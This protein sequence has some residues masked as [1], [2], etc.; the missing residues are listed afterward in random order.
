MFGCNF[1]LCISVMTEI[2][3]VCVC[4]Y[5]WAGGFSLRTTPPQLAS[6]WLTLPVAMVTMADFEAMPTAPVIVEI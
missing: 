4:V 3:G 6:A 1:C 2:R 5:Q